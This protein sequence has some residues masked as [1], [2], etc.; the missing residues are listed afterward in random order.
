[1]LGIGA[2][3]GAVLILRWYWWRINAWSEITATVTAAVLTFVL[4]K[5]PFTGNGAVVT[6]KATLI[7]AGVTT[8]A[9]IVGT[10]ATKPEPTEKLLSFY[11]RVHPSI[12]GWQPIAKLCPELPQVRD[13]AANTANWVAGCVMVYTAMFGIGMLVFRHWL[14]GVLLLLAS[15]VAGW[16]IFWNLSRQGWGTLS[17][18]LERTTAKN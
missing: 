15:G 8:I 1:M 13:F 18:S 6:A 4:A 17:G 2:G 3:T 12:Y 11:R 14:S 7:T 10:F 16:L 5:V 9:W